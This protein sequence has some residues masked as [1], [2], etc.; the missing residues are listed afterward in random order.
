MREIVDKHFYD[1]W[2]IPYYLGYTIDLSEWWD[3]YKAANN[4]L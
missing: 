1:N 3:R 2:V 4:A